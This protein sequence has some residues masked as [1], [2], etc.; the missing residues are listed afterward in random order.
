MED[1]LYLV[2]EARRLWLESLQEF[3]NGAYGE[4]LEKKICSTLVDLFKEYVRGMFMSLG[5]G[6]VWLDC[7][8]VPPYKVLATLLW[9]RYVLDW[10]ILRSMVLF[11]N[12]IHEEREHKEELQSIYDALDFGVRKRLRTALCFVLQNEMSPKNL[13]AARVFLLFCF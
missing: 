11:R 3:R 8:L 2:R 9:T 7:R 1:P 10:F 6:S 5:T 4:R 12:H 13:W